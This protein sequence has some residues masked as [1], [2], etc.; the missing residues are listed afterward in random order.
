MSERGGTRLVCTDCGYPKAGLKGKPCPECACADEEMV[1]ASSGS[2]LGWMFTIGVFVCPFV[3]LFAGGAFAAGQGPKDAAGFACF[4]VPVYWTFGTID[5]IA[6]SGVAGR[7]QPSATF[8]AL[9]CVVAVAIC[10]YT[11]AK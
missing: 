2:G 1:E 3:V 11:I 4:M 6:R 10:V 9:L 7:L 8:M 5:L